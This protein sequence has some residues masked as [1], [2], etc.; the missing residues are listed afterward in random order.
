VITVPD[1]SV[2]VFWL[3]KLTARFQPLIGQ[4]STGAFESLHQS[5]QLNAFVRS[6]E[7]MH[8][9]RHD[10]IV[11][12]G[13]GFCGQRKDVIS[14]ESSYDL[15]AQRATSKTLIE[16]TLDPARPLLLALILRKGISIKLDLPK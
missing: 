1:H 5:G 11:V 14:N 10:Y 9:V 6:Q 2:E 15:G 16:V 3:P 7:N 13:E 12:Q 8:M 4:K